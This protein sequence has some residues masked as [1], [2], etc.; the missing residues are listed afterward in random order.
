MF[1]SAP[2]TISNKKVKNDMSTPAWLVNFVTCAIYKT[3]REIPFVMA[4]NEKLL[5]IIA[6]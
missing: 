3:P 4:K 6:N 5:I 1:I 2:N